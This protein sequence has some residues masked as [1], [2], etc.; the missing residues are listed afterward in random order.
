MKTSLNIIRAHL[1]K[2]EILAQLAEEAA[3]L[4]Q[5]ALKF[6]RTYSDINPTPVKGPD[7]FNELLEELADVLVCIDALGFNRPVDVALLQHIAEIKQNRW[8]A[9]LEAVQQAK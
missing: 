1:D 5:A 8:A 9:R 3:E 2:P 4:S 7:A 6:R